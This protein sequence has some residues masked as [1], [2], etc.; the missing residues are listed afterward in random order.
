MDSF[1]MFKNKSAVTSL[2]TILFIKEVIEAHPEHRS[3]I[4]Q[5]ICESFEDINSPLVL[6]VALWIMVEYTTSQSDVDQAFETIKRNIG[7][8]PLVKE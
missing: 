7:T 5:K 1:L 3:P 6:R 4:F 8:L 2:E